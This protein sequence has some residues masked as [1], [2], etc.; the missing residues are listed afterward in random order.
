MKDSNRL[1]FSAAVAPR[2]AAATMAF[3]LSLFVCP[4][5]GQEAPGRGLSHDTIAAGTVPATPTVVEPFRSVEVAASDGCLRLEL[6]ASQLDGLRTGP[7]RRLIRLPSPDGEPLLLEMTRFNVVTPRTR[8]VIGGPNGDTPIA[9]PDV[10][11]FRGRL[12]DAPHSHAFLAVSPGGMA[13]G[14]VENDGRRFYVATV[15]G[16]RPRAGG[17]AAITLHEGTGAF[18]LPEFTE[19][20]GVGPAKRPIDVT[21]L[22]ARPRGSITDVR[23]PRQANVAIDADQAYVNI[24][25]NVP[26]AQNYIV[27]LTAAVSDIYDR[28]INVNL[29]LD[30]VRLWPAG[31]EPFTATDLF[32]FYDHWTINEDTTGLNYIHL[33]SGRRDTGYGGVAF[34]GGTCQGFAYGISAFLLGSFPSPLGPSHLGNWDVIVMAHEMGHNS[35]TFHTHDGYSPPIDNC[36]NGTPTRGTIMSY[37]HIFPGGT[38][39]TELY[40]HRIVEDVIEAE[41]LAGDC[42]YYDCNSNGIAD[43][44]E[45]DADPDLDQNGDTVLDECQDCNSNGINDMDDIG[46]GVPDV[47]G[48]YILDEC[49]P[50]CNSNGVPDPWEC[51][52]NPAI[53][54]NGNNVPDECD[55]DC[56]DNSVI[57]WLDVTSG[58]MTDVDRDGQ[59]DVCQDC[60][61]DGIEDWKQL[62]RGDN[63]FVADLSGYVREFYSTSGYPVQNLASG[64]VSA[65]H[66]CVFGPDR[67]LYVAG[68][69]D[70]R[71]VRVDVD[72]GATS[73]FVSAGSGGL[74]GPSSLIFDPAG[75]LLVAS[76]LTSSVIKYDG[77]TGALIGTFVGA[78]SGGL[79]GPYGLTFGPNGNLFVTSADHRVLQFDG[80]TGALVG[81]F[82]S[83]GSG[84]LS[85]PRGLCF[86]PDGRLLV[87]SYANNRVL[88]YNGATGAFIRIF[89]QTITVAGAWGIRIGPNGNVFVVRS[90]SDVRVYEYD[91]TSGLFMRSYVRGD[92]PLP[93]PSGLDFRSG[94]TN[95]CNANRVLDRCD[96]EWTDVDLFVDTLMADP[97]DP[98]LKCLYNRN[99]DS[100][101]DGLD[102]Q[103]FLDDLLP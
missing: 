53:D 48:N 47:N 82:V 25:G 83:A 73:T 50:D 89:N 66:D 84:G 21:N 88:E 46:L 5:L 54:A 69:G 65:P 62:G 60:D 44:L 64:A 10:V 95:D 93:S 55:P 2:A 91:V 33:L 49:E 30:F 81:T 19:F 35:G 78:G 77:Q 74:D 31:G 1:S 15:P 3:A 20:C 14:Y 71:V 36:G 8:F 80:T 16:S 100:E 96:P 28:D 23:G 102:V 70:D 59:P 24:F 101:L 17:A 34:V 72:S 68:S 57:D 94:F 27:Q 86:T 41:L 22:P 87:S 6:D 45:I 9:P 32:T 29:V 7:V 58:G 75:D 39:N 76:R 67:Q 61:D 79:T 12:V 90:H 92:G 63:L 52:L 18:A 37:C 51:D 103:P 56:N 26:D 40:M 85:D 43:N 13:N 97:P 4:A 11:T 42:F 99:G 38:A 98:V